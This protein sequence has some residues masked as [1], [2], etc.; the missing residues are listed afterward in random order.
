LLLKSPPSAAE[1]EEAGSMPRAAQDCEGEGHKGA[2]SGDACSNGVVEVV[3]DVL[4]TGALQLGGGESQGGQAPASGTRS[5]EQVGDDEEQDDAPNG[6]AQGEGS[7]NGAARSCLAISNSSS[8]G[9][10]NIKQRDGTCRLSGWSAGV[11]DDVEA[12]GYDEAPGTANEATARGCG[13]QVAEAV[14]G[15]EVHVEDDDEDGDK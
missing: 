9:P 4:Q 8:G 11:A 15:G 2:G 3:S 1:E 12:N 7:W 13:V 6:S 5:A 14:G 10:T